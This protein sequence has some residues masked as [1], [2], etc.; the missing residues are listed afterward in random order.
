VS[1]QALI[2]RYAARG[3]ALSLT[4]QGQLK[5]SAA[6]G[7]LDDEARAEL[8][9]RKAD[10]VAW[11]SAA[12][13]SAG[14]Q[15]GPELV[16]LAHQGPVPLS[17][18]QQRLWLLDRI[19]PG[20]AAYVI[21][22]AFRLRGELDA[23]ALRLAFHA[24]TT[25][26]ES[27]RTRFLRSEGQAV[28]VVDAEARLDW[29]EH[30]VDGEDAARA[31]ISTEVQHGF[32]LET[33][34]LLR[35]R[36]Y[37][38][39]PGAQVLYLCMHHIISDGW[40][41]GILVREL[42]AHYAAIS[43][44]GSAALDPLP[45]DYR[46]YSIWQQKY[47][48]P[49][50]T[51]RLSDYWRRQLHGWQAL[52]LP[53][54]RPRPARPALR[55]AH[56]RL[57]LDA[58]SGEAAARLARSHNTTPFAVLL[59]VFGLLLQRQSGQHDIVLGTDVANRNRQQLEGLIGF[60][61]NQLVIR[62][63]LSGR[64]RF[65][66]LL[67]RVHQT[68]LDAYAHQ[69]LPFDV[70]VHTLLDGREYN[71]SPFFQVKFILQNTPGP[72]GE[73]D[74]QLQTFDLHN[75]PAKFDMT[76]SVAPAGDGQA[77]DIEYNPEIFDA[78]TIATY[79]QRYADLLAAVLAQPDA[80][81]HSYVLDAPAQAAWRAD[82]AAR[83]RSAPAQRQ[84]LGTLVSEWAHS[85]PQAEAVRDVARGTTLSYAELDAEANRLAQTLIEWGIGTESRVGV[86]L[87]A[88]A[89]QALAAV[90]IS[91]AGAALVP[92]DPAYPE[93][94]IAQIVRDADLQLLIADA[95]ALETIPAQVLGATNAIDIDEHRVLWEHNSADAPEVAVAT[96]Q[97]AYIVFTSGTTGQPKGVMVSVD[98]VANLV[99]E[100]R[101]RFAAGPGKRVLAFASVGFDAAQWELLMALGQGATLVCEARERIMPGRELAQ[102]IAAQGITHLTLPP[103]ALGLLPLSAAAHLQVLVLAGEACRDEFVR[104]WAGHGTRIF[105]AYGPSEATVCTSMIELAAD[106]EGFRNNIGASVQGV[107]AY[108]VDADGALAAPGVPGELCVAGAALA[109]G[110]WN[111]ARQTAQRFVPDAH[112]GLPGARLYRS[113]DRARLRGGEIEFLGRA[114]QQVKIRGHRV[115]LGEIEACLLRQPGISGA[116]V[117]VT[118]TEPA[119]LLAYAVPAE[120]ATPDA[121]ALRQA[122][123]QSLPEYMVPR[124]L[125]LIPQ[126]PMTANGKIDVAALP[127]PTAARSLGAGEAPASALERELLALWQEQLDVQAIS[128]Q[129]NFFDVGGDSLLLV[130]LQEQIA[131]RLGRQVDVASLFK[132][133][134]VASLAAHLSQSGTV[135]ESPQEDARIARRRE[136][137]Q[138]RGPRGAA[139]EHGDD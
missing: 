116:A 78:Q 28:Q 107:A 5:L 74:A 127:P 73:D 22:M 32:D 115:E 131:A 97:L 123:R 58:A 18:A 105:N 54:D 72:G 12:A 84:S 109:R 63:D 11:L 35:L 96:G 24:I 30:E 101:A 66:D 102:F 26:H 61:V 93:A 89:A 87:P 19:D 10:I 90:A 86:C 103:S 25:R 15:A 128:T 135:E 59:A 16:R 121:D 98:G 13:A 125:M 92:I 136:A 110:Y 9:A 80:L 60:F 70:L 69:D 65:S 120:G 68:T 4:E 119:A 34:P 117:I 83:Q 139:Q 1:I 76:W 29:Q 55:G 2:S 118:R 114:D 38:C 100:Q 45:V 94:R 106:A 81:L 40:S 57:R 71:L 124:Q 17:N 75:L 6:K 31:A 53:L 49:E 33:G 51:N 43:T 91:K 122:L 104:R 47:L 95:A 44:G 37:H 130:A 7:V 52:E 8:A 132:Y 48:M 3:V 23:N 99:A 64:P 21:P 82:A 67:V 14:A 36:L 50:L 85:Q 108:I 88:S 62:L 137:M 126:L 111:D 79:A 41:I 42:G 134:T 133:P 20:S 112:S 46:D 77:V 138:R 27:L 129:D 56:H 113:G 39:G